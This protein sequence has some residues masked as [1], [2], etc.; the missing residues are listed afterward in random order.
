MIAHRGVPIAFA[1]AVV[2]V[3]V[4]LCAWC[5][6]SCGTSPLT[7]YA[8]SAELAPAPSLPGMNQSA[9]GANH[10]PEDCYDIL[11]GAH[12]MR[13]GSDIVIAN[14]RVENPSRLIADDESFRFLSVQMPTKL[15]GHHLSLPSESVE[16]RYSRGGQFQFLRCEGDV[17]VNPR[18]SISTVLHDDGAITVVVDLE[19][20]S[21]DAKGLRE[22]RLVQVQDEFVA[23]RVMATTGP[24]IVSP[25]FLPQRDGAHR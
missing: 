15:V 13:A 5:L 12:H 19:L 1:A 17:S 25:S 14:Y 3:G 9:S 11:V 10:R 23:R 18:G 16:V 6:G 20:T 4:A 2:L 21:I 22:S 24:A 7:I 8:E